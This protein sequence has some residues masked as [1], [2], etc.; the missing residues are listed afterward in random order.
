MATAPGVRGWPAAMLF[1]QVGVPGRFREQQ[2]AACGVADFPFRLDSAWRRAVGEEDVGTGDKGLSG[3][4][5][6]GR[7]VTVLPGPEPGDFTATERAADVKP[8]R[9]ILP[10]RFARRIDRCPDRGP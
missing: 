3:P 4:G 7:R 8:P 5:T 10:E 9:P 1:D 6:Q 2:P